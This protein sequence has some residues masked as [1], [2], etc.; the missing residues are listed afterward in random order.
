MLAAA[1]QPVKKI[2]A[3][4]KGRNAAKATE[5]EADNLYSVLH[6]CIEARVMLTSNLWTKRGLVNGS[7]GSIIELISHLAAHACFPDQDA[8]SVGGISPLSPAADCPCRFHVGN[9]SNG[10]TGRSIIQ[11]QPPS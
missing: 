2:N 7:M 9:S 10:S 5:E 11:R 8:R 3:L 6:V 4:H 1:N